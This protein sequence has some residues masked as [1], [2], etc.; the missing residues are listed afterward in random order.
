MSKRLKELRVRAG[1]SQRQLG[2]LIGLDQSVASPRM[3]QYERGA[4]EPHY[5]L[6]RRIAAA[7]HAPT[8]Y[9]YADEPALAEIILAYGGL[10]PNDRKRAAL[11]L[12][13]AT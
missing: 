3:N 10:S 12:P 9:F 2:V 5:G 6:V 7:L 4:H 11:K 1:I 13:R 8:A